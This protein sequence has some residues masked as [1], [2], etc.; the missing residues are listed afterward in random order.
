[1]SILRVILFITAVNA[2]LAAPC[3]CA[4]GE[5]DG[6]PSEE[7][8]QVLLM[9][10]A[11]YGTPWHTMVYKAVCDAF[12]ADRHAEIRLYT[13]FTGIIQ[14][15]KPGYLEKLRDLYVQ[16]YAD[17][18][19]DLILVI[20]DPASFF[21]IEYAEAVFPEVPVVSV[22]EER[23]KKQVLSNPNMVGVIGATKIRE[24][25]DTA[26]ALHPDTRHVAVIAGSSGVDR[27]YEESA[28][29]V[30]RKYDGRFDVIDLTGLAMDDLLARVARLPE[31][32]VCLYLLTLKDADG[33]EFVPQKMLPRISQ[34][35]NAPMYGLW[36]SSLGYGIVGGYL[37]SAE[38]SGAKVAE[39]GL[40]ILKGEKPSDISFSHDLNHYMFDWRQLRRWNIHE[41]DLPAESI[42]RYK[43]LSFWDRYKWR[44]MLFTLFM[45]AAGLG[46][47][48]FRT[49]AFEEKIKKQEEIQR[50]LE[51]K[52][53]ERTRDLQR[54]KDRAEVA[55]LAKS[56]FLANMSHE[57]RTPLNSILGFSR[58]LENFENLEKKQREYLAIVHRNGE[59]LLGLIEDVLNLS[60]IEAGRITVDHAPVDLFQMLD[61]LEDTMRLRAEKKGLSLVF[62]RDESIPR[63]IDADGTKLRQV[64]INIVGNALKFT[65]RGEV[66]VRVKPGRTGIN[67]EE[68]RTD[69][70]SQDHASTVGKAEALSFEISDTGPGIAPEELNLVFEVF[71]QTTTGKMAGKGS[72]LGLSISK[73]F[74]E[75]MG[76][77]IRVESEV[78]QGATFAFDIPCRTVEPVGNRS[79]TSSD[80]ATGLQP[81]QPSFRLLVADDNAASRQLIIDIL[82]PLGFE[83][84]EA[85]NGRQAVDCHRHWHPHLVWM[86]MC[87]P[88]MDGYEAVAAIRKRECLIAECEKD[89]F[90][91]PV[92]IVAVTASCLEDARESALIGGCDDFL[93]KPLRESDLFAM[94]EKH[95]GTRF[96]YKAKQNE[97]KRPEETFDMDDSIAAL[98]DD[99]LRR[100]KTALVNTKM[101]DVEAIVEEIRAM[102]GRLSEK[103]EAM[104]QE[105]AYDE[106]LDLIAGKNKAV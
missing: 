75:L 82:K 4:A 72:G 65:E 92:K 77:N 79:S 96:I 2:M 60:K 6:Q 14:H 40:R 49:K 97:E 62:T 21:L 22:Y 48:H 103:L 88:H 58:L 83:L 10:A 32:T 73:K 101:D 30:L 59:H 93:R 105:F 104:A 64:L 38:S 17:K 52:V 56:A 50:S 81:G 46:Y 34:A 57:L 19:M 53:E 74:V 37:L 15:F 7:P 20:G 71:E 35:S 25:L 39:I 23:R 98:P 5:N 26:L 12:D 43:E 99:L 90:R 80:R 55:N 45:I 51:A 27:F 86:D 67:R 11:D 100:F 87:M 47:G 54:A 18:E 41:R 42:V 76:G 84:R 89:A 29:E 31:K 61:D 24:T 78:G 94:L 1:M 28:R 13:E 91:V 8:K 44:F 70:C 33:K 106:I 16:K 3:I 63:F 66:A 68:D 85:K 36:E 95:L 9:V 102:D 69:E